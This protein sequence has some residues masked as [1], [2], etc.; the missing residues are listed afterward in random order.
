MYIPLCISGYMCTYIYMSANSHM[1]DTDIHTVRQ[2]L[3]LHTYN[4]YACINT[5]TY[6]YIHI[7]SYLI[8]TEMQ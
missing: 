6:A 8:G 1:P 4:I 2:T 5:Y 7:D 3:M